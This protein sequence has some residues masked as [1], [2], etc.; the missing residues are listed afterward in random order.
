MSESQA[1]HKR[2]KIEILRKERNKLSLFTNDEIVYI[3]NSK[4]A[5]RKLQELIIEFNKLVG[6]KINIQKSV[7][8]LYSNN[9]LPEREIKET[10]SFIIISKI[11]RYLGINLPQEVK[12][13]YS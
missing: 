4:D 13:L 9:E 2:K 1:Q 11:I 7:A 10:I 12:D 3:K 8:F 6:Y 5:A